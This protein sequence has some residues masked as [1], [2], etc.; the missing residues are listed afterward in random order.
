M[1]LKL[2]FFG[3]VLGIALCACANGCSPHEKVEFKVTLDGLPVGGA[4]VLLDPGENGTQL[5]ASGLT[6]NEGVCSI[7]TLGKPGAARGSY[8]I[9]VM[10]VDDL[11]NGP[12]KRQVKANNLLP[13][14][15][16]TKETTPFTVTVPASGIVPLALES[17]K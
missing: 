16:A 14:K 2:V 13:A 12:Q 5:S 6:N 7:S 17:D 1:K 3:T 4:I 8:K 15:Y 11:K 9:L 10:K